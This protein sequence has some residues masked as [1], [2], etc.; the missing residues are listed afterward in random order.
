MTKAC[1]LYWV[2]FMCLCP[3]VCHG[4]CFTYLYSLALLL[5]LF[6]LHH[7]GGKK[8]DTLKK[9]SSHKCQRGDL[10]TT[11][12][13]IFKERSW[14]KNKCSHNGWMPVAREATAYHPGNMYCGCSWRSS[15]SWHPVALPLCGAW[16][17]MSL[18]LPAAGWF[19]LL[20]PSPPTP[21]K[22]Y[23]VTM[24]LGR[25][26][27]WHLQSDLVWK[28]SQNELNDSCQKLPTEKQLQ[29]WKLS[30]MWPEQWIRVLTGF[31]FFCWLH[32]QPH[33][34]TADCSKWSWSASMFYTS[35]PANHHSLNSV[36]KISINSM[37]H[38]NTE[39]LI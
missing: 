25:K 37:G 39:S 18:P 9:K 3:I 19:L 36:K 1:C 6:L 30:D 26:C 31:F 4:V 24:A 13:C 17:V 38:F 7:Q 15:P 34:S 32:F 21:P 16:S 20:L 33:T 29:D 2:W 23:T 10:L 27:Y 22:H 12:S 35:N 14:Q 8:M 28:S 5:S 11:I